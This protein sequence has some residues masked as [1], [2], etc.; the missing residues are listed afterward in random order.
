MARENF[1]FRERNQKPPKYGHVAKLFLNRNSNTKEI[2]KRKHANSQQNLA[3]FL[4][5]TDSKNEII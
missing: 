5:A 2:N 1:T 4:A 3:V